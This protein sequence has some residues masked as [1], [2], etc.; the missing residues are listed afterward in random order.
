Q[1]I[2]RRPLACFAIDDGPH[3]LAVFVEDSA[4]D[5]DGL[6]VGWRCGREGHSAKLRRL[7]LRERYGAFLCQLSHA[8]ATL[9]VGM[10]ATRIAVFVVRPRTHELQ[11][12]P[13]HDLVEAV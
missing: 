1:L 5:A 13:V 12:R 7:I 2:E 11:S 9:L 3:P 4:T 10:F 6:A 8:Q